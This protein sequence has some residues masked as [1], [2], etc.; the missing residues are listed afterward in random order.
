MASVQGIKQNIVNGLNAAKAKASKAYRNIA[1]GTV[2]AGTYLKGLSKDTVQFVK[3]KPIKAGIIGLGIA[4]GVG[5]LTKFVSI[6]ISK[7]KEHK[8]EKKLEAA[9]N[10]K[11]AVI[12][13]MAEPAL[14]EAK[15]IIE[16]GAQ[17]VQAQQAEIAR[18]Q[19]LVKTHE[20]VH[21]S[22][23]EALDAYRDALSE[24]SAG[25]EE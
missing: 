11:N 1:L 10:Q 9:I 19:E 21:E 2:V 5:A 6:G 12:A 18:L 3:A 22:D 17:V 15:K 14:S 20:L 16:D 13:A 25:V 4:A 24:K 7:F 23:K 8:E